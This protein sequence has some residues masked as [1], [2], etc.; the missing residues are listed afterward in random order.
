MQMLQ[1]RFGD[2]YLNF[3]VATTDLHQVNAAPDYETRDLLRIG[4]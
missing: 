1:Q 4:T 2:I 3:Y